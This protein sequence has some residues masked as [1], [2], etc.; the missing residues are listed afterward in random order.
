MKTSLMTRS[1]FESGRKR[2]PRAPFLD[3]WAVPANDP[4]CLAPLL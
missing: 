3:W 1:V 2:R 4:Q